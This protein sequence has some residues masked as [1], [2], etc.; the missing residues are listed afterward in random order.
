MTPN[1]RLAAIMVADVVGYSRLMEADEAGTLAALKERRK[2]VLEPV[3]KAHGGR[4][5]K[6][7]GDGVLVEFASAVNAV[8][9]AIE[10]QRKMAEADQEV[11][12]DRRMELRI[13]INLGDVIGEGSDIYG[14]GVNIAAR[15]EALAEHGGICVS[16]KVY[17]E[18]KSKITVGFD[19]IGVQALKNIAEPMRVYRVRLDGSAANTRPALSLPDKPS[20]AVL[21]FVNMSTD[22]EQEHFADGLTED[23]IT[24]LSRHAELFVIARNSTFAY[25]GKATDVRQIARD[26]G[27]RY[28]LEGSARRAASRV[29]I[30]V[31]LIDAIGGGHLWAE[32]F[33]RELQDI[34]AVQ[35]EV[36]AK[37]VED[38]VGR[39]TQPS[40][41][42]RRPN[43]IA[44]YDLCV[45]A[46][47]LIELSP[48]SAREAQLLLR[49]AIALEPTYAE[50]HHLLAMA[51]WMGW[52]HWGESMEPNRQI[53]IELAQEAVELDPNDSMCHWMLGHILAYEA[54]WA[55]ANAEFAMALEL[56]PNN[57]HLWADL[58]DFSVLSGRVDEGLEQI[59]KAI[60]L[61]PHPDVWYYLLLGQA[62]YAARDYESAVATLRRDE[63][64]RTSSR[65]FLAASLAQLGKLDDA[66]RE[67]EMF[68]VTNPHWTIS[69]WVETQPFRDEAMRQHFVEG[70]RKAGLPE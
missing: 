50:A 64:Y 36:I 24:D 6:V 52:A 58:S 61:N 26:L 34:F 14:E 46:R 12:D 28:L 68:L 40:S 25:K 15:L 62:Q 57:A 54:R 53:A 32:R 3:V 45:R 67:T 19:D 56:D 30:N 49:Q 9:G 47:P 55:E 70:Y 8:Q 48:Q 17:G 69:H 65:K 51:T 5:V 59:R 63:T 11:T 2:G 38:L 23:L 4:V 39:L 43:N 66:R 16:A 21:P 31:Q 27:V 37:I 29:R 22:P 33:D 18:V 10:L 7:M 1:R 35:D 44:A 41:P 20:I 60:R 42:R 13:G